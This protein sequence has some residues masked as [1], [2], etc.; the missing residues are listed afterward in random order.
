MTWKP[1]V[2]VEDHMERATVYADGRVT[3]DVDVTLS[4]EDYKEM[5][6]GYRCCRCYGHVDTAFPETCGFPFCD[7]YPRGFPMRQRQREVMER[8]FDG[9]KWVGVT[10]EIADRLEE[11][12]NRIWTPT[13]H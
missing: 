13:K 6:A 11:A 3:R 2:V 9:L 7:G 8:E 1:P 4:E 12:N 5:W 10:K